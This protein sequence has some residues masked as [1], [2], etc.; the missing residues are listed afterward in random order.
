MPCLQPSSASTATLSSDKRKIST[1]AEI[2]AYAGALLLAG[3]VSKV[4]TLAGIL[5]RQITQLS[6]GM[7]HTREI[8]L[9]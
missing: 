7:H 9:K 5:L 1:Q 2:I 3:Q 4:A 6:V 8:G